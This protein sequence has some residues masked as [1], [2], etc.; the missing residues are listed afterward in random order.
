MDVFKTNRPEAILALGSAMAGGFPTSGVL[1]MFFTNKRAA[2]VARV[3]VPDVDDVA[4]WAG[5]LEAIATQM[6]ADG[7]LPIFLGTE[8]EVP[9]HR[10]AAAQ[11]IEHTEFRVL[12][13]LMVTPERWLNLHDASETG[14]HQ[15]I[16]DAA[17]ALGID[18]TAERVEYGAAA[19]PPALPEEADKAAE[20]ALLDRL[21]ENEAQLAELPTLTSLVMDGERSIEDDDVAGVLIHAIG[22]PVARDVLLTTML[23]DSTRGYEMQYASDR[24]NAGDFD[25]PVI[26]ESAQIVMGMVEISPDYA[27]LDHACQLL[28][29]LAQHTPRSRRAALLTTL[30]WFHYAA[31]RT[32]TAVE[33]VRA[34][35]KL[36]SIY[37]FARICETVY[38]ANPTPVWIDNRTRDRQRRAA[39]H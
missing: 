21:V 29:E 26:T 2:V 13:C 22:I 17:D 35:R 30:S 36:D 31:G 15:D 16:A 25:Q 5:S 14:T 24:W 34:A 23:F 28:H 11:L 37:E 38:T 32:A 9:A 1:A 4:E 18:Y 33:I 39:E 10:S 6:G 20:A 3:D 12:P 27:R 19:V 7:I 8:E